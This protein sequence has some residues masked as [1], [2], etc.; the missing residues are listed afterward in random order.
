MKIGVLAVQGAV[1]EH[2]SSLREVMEKLDIQGD[3][4]SLKTPETVDKLDGLIIP[5][6][7]SS[8]ISRLIDTFRIREKVLKCA[9]EGLYIMGT[10]AGSILLAKEG[11]RAVKKSDTN[12]LE[13][14]DMK[15]KRNA[16]GRQ[17]ES[18]EYPIDIEE[19]A[20][21]FKAVFIRAPAIER[22]GERCQ[23][24]S[25]LDDVIV[26]ARQDNFFAF[27][28]HPELTDDLRVHEYFLKE[29]DI[30]Y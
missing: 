18:F 7:E 6:G 12:L 24:L 17:R 26:A 13:L 9:S 4:Y 8:T 3:V 22:C 16:F 28:F 5:G 25:R 21:D 19:I 14:M 30:D 27:V 15:V 23:V 20:T 29:I 2:V 10:C 1:S 11:G